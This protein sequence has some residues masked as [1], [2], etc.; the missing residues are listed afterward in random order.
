[1]ASGDASAGG[2]QDDKPSYPLRQRAAGWFACGRFVVCG[3]EDYAAVE[4]LAVALG[5]EIGLVAQSQVDDAA[6]ARGHRRKVEG[7]SGLANFFGG[8]RGGHAEFLETD[9]TLVFA[10]E[11]NFF[12][13]GGGQVQNF[14]GQ[15]FQSTEKF[16]AAI[17]KK[18]RVGAGEVD[19]DFRFLPVGWRWGIDYD[20]VFEMETS[21]GDHGL[22]EFVDAVGGG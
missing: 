12:V 6:L 1:M 14:E 22:E 13:F 2:A 11:G 5:A 18:S 15:Q 8:Y 17:E 19:K 21:V 9:G 20:A 4:A 3:V 10:I 7:S 16:A